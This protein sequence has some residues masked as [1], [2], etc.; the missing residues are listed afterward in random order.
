[1]EKNPQKSKPKGP[2]LGS[3]AQ[4][5][6]DRE[7]QARVGVGDETRKVARAGG[8]DHRGSRKLR[9]EESVRHVY[10]EGRADDGP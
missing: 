9:G 10:F 1:M 3:D 5:E 7:S 6:G 2:E 4:C 8:T